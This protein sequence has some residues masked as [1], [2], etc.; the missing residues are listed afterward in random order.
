MERLL[1]NKKSCEILGLEYEELSP[2][3]FLNL[4]LYV[5]SSTE[6]MVYLQIV[7]MDDQNCIFSLYPQL[8]KKLE[9]ECRTLPRHGTPIKAKFCL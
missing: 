5:E 3:K 8:C 7:G 1:F 2:K 9:I 6:T 4:D